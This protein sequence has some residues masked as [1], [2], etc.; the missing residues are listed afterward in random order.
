[1]EQGFLKTKPQENGQ[2]AKTAQ[3]NTTLKMAS[4]PDFILLRKQTMVPLLKGKP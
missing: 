1:M 3:G 4:Q 2:A